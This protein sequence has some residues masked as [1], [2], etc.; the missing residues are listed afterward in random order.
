[1]RK[2]TVSFATHAA[3]QWFALGTALLLMAV[4]LTMDIVSEYTQTKTREHDRLNAGLRVIGDNL[5]Q[6]LES[7]RLALDS[8]RNDLPHKNDVAGLKTLNLRLQAIAVATPGIRSIG[9]LDENGNVLASSRPEF[10]G[11]YFGHRD[12]FKT[13]QKNPDPEQLF[14]SPPFKSVSGVD[15]IAVTR[16][17]TGP[18]GEFSGIVSAALDPKYFSTLLGSVLYAP[19]MWSGLVH[20]DGTLYLMNPAR[21]AVTGSDLN[22][23]GSLFNRHL[24][25]GQSTTITTG[26]TVAVH[27]LRMMAHRTIQPP[28]L[29]MDKSLIVGVSRDP[30]AVFEI[31]RH[32]AMSRGL[33][34]LIMATTSML[35]LYAY[36]R[37][38]RIQEQ[39]SARAESALRESEERFRATFDAAAIG[40]ALVSIEGRFIKANRALCAILGYSAEELQE[41]TWQALTHPDDLESDLALAQEILDGIRDSYD[42][43]KRYFHKSGH[44]IWI[45]LSGSAV[46]DAAGQ[47]IYFIAQIQ[48]ITERKTLLEKL[49]LQANRD[50]LTGLSNRRHF[51]EQG[52]IELSRAKRYGNALS[53]F[54]LD[55]DH[56]KKINDTHGHKA[57]DLVLQKLSTVCQQTLRTVDIVGRIGGE[58]FAVLLPETDAGQAAEVGERL[59]E[60]I[61]NS[62]VI[63]DAGLPLQFTVSI[64]IATLKD[65]SINLDMLLNLADQAL[66]DAKNSG[67]NRVCINA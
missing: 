2:S 25:S 1:M 18:R 62:N 50:Y 67:R 58:E 22:R 11:K 65:N 57:G 24:A 37:R 66:Y 12:Y 9:V 34:F 28:A 45:L 60:N 20:G 6:K 33:L 64:G 36:Q 7:A 44:V 53:I 40:M 39:L 48:D 5:E 41:K 8:V 16:V 23:P 46:R 19:D 55:I 63:L 35:G 10:V 52:E 56:F 42:M 30:D 47:V 26:M 13:A 27:E 4:A 21:D 15:V 49:E 29:R 51:L 3:M 38:R 31:W 54:M 32:N 61:A 43:E 59:R 14:I 17:V